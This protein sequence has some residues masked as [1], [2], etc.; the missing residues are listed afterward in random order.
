MKKL[1]RFYLGLV[2]LFLYAPIVVLIVFSFNASKSRNVWAGFTLDWYKK[3]FQNEII[4]KSL[5]A[6][7][8]VAVV[9]SIVATVLGTAAAVGIHSMKKTA[10]NI[11]LN[12]NYLPIVNPEIVT[13]VSL[14]MLFLFMGLKRDYF[15]LIL[16]HITFCVPYVILSVMPKLRQLNPCLFEAAQDL[17]CRPFKAFFKVVLPEI[18]PGVFSGLL[19][20]FTYS[21]DDFVISYFT[22]DIQ[23]LPI[24]IY[25]MTR[26]RVSPEINAL[27]TLIFVVVLF[28]LIAMNWSDAHKYRM[29]KKKKKKAATY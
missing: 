1:S 23:T 11:I 26:R 19:M 28:I 22:T 13:G 15:T 7:L 17:G 16:T 29:M 21:I 6:T 24:T 18:M 9:A 10:R 8:L 20:S 14:M 4:I 12:I 5:L 25:S 27:S 3:L 2:F